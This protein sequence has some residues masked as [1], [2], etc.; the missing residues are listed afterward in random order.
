MTQGLSHASSFIPAIPDVDTYS[1]ACNMNAGC[2]GR[3][4][5]MCSMMS[6]LSVLMCVFFLKID[7]VQNLNSH[8]ELIIFSPV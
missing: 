2:L 8:T 7:A 3:L 4:L 5:N 6:E 1:T